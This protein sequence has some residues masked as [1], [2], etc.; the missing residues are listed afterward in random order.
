MSTWTEYDPFSGMT[1]TN[2]ATNDGDVIVHKEQDVEKLLDYTAHIRN[3][4]L[5]DRGIKHGLWHY[6]T[7]PY[8][9]AYEMLTKYGVNIHKKADTD[10]VFDIINKHYPKLKLT[11]KNHSS[12]RSRSPNRAT[13]TDAGID[14][15][16]TS[17]L[18]L[19]TRER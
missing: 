13:T 17:G 9:V 18:I 12:R 5:A 10:R 1:E 8:T 16:S 7:I 6:C 2:V 15:T 19:T 11:N 4:G 3:E 14:S